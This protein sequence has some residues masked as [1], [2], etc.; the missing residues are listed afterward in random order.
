MDGLVDGQKSGWE[1]GRKGGWMHA[2]RDRWI[3]GSVLV[4]CGVC[5]RA[6]AYA[7]ACGVLQIAKKKEEA[8]ALSIKLQQVS[9]ES[10]HQQVRKEADHQIRPCFMLEVH[11]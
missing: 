1:G 11:L 7:R 9:Q 5:V 6:R 3:H 8:E 4:W 10:P 2:C